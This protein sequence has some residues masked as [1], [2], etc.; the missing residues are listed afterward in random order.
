[1]HVEIGKSQ[2]DQDVTVA[3]MNRQIGYCPNMIWLHLDTIWRYGKSNKP[4]LL[5]GQRA[6]REFEVESSSLKPLKNLPD[7]HRVF[8][9]YVQVNQN[10]VQESNAQ[11]VYALAEDQVHK[12]L[13]GCKHIGQAK[14]N[15][16][17]LKVTLS[18]PESCVPLVAFL[19]PDPVVGVAGVQLGEIMRT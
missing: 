14:C 6:L 4:N 9:T 3:S 13:E 19:D 12:A 16:V 1:M 17:V 5:C 18:C 15:N 10:V 2:E 8:F 11:Y 7:M